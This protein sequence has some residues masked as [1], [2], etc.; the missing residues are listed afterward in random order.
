MSAADE[1]REKRRRWRLEA[2]ATRALLAER[3]PR[4]FAPKGEPKR[5]LKLG[6]HND[7]RAAVPDIS[8]RLIRIALDDY[9]TGNSYLRAMAAGA[10]RLDLDGWPA[11]EVS[12][13]HAKLARQQLER[14][15]TPNKRAPDAQDR[16]A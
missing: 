12:I 6:I 10:A 9:T 1:R 15:E 16:A 14:R 5:P 11:G 2:T 7:L 13:T 8:R 3:F 4:C